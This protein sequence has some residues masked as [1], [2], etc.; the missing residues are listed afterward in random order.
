LKDATNR[1]E[2]SYTKIL[3]KGFLLGYGFQLGPYYDLVMS[4][5]RE[6]IVKFPDGELEITSRSIMMGEAIA[7][8][9]LTLNNLVNEEL[10]YRR[11]CGFRLDLPW[12]DVPQ[13]EWRVVHIGG[14]DHLLHGPPGYLDLM[15][16][17]LKKSGAMI[18]VE[19]HGIS[20]K[21]VK[22]TEKFINIQNI[23]KNIKRDLPLNPEDPKDAIIVDSI[24]VRL[25]EKGLSTLLAKDNKNVAVG[26]ASQ[27]ARTI[28]WLPR[29]LYPYNSIMVYRE[30]FIKRMGSLLP[31]RHKNPRAFAQVFLP[32][33]IGGY[34]LGP[35][36]E[37]VDWLRQSPYP[38]QKMISKLQHG[39]D[40]RHELRLL[41]RINT[42]PSRRG[43][44]TD[45]VG[46]FR[47]TLLGQLE[48][49]PD[50]VDAVRFDQLRVMFPGSDPRDTLRQAAG[51]GWLSFEE[52]ADYITRGLIFRELLVNNE[53]RKESFNSRPMVQTMYHIYDELMDLTDGFDVPDW[54][55]LPWREVKALVFGAK[56]Q[57]YFDTNQITSFDRAS[58]TRD[59]DNYKDSPD[60]ESDSGEPEE[61]SESFD[62]YDAP[63]ISGWSR[64]QPT[65]VVPPS[66]VQIP[67]ILIK[68][69]SP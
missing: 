64:G 37:V 18:S 25:L 6:R 5:I 54:D 39:A 13:R 45:K 14:D 31:S 1:Q 12:Q 7:K 20:K 63:Y 53:G 58:D 65:L 62:F 10:A 69:A 21:A 11:F 59:S 26:K 56:I 57:W 60:R 41:R 55:N 61:E 43:V 36:S 47:D 9:S 2:F 24:K 27:F 28:E 52:Y 29:E 33:E 42:N 30:L 3:L 8:P 49:Y 4:L 40:I 16:K 38:I 17:N 66:F 67:E 15:T 34:G 23:M 50:M 68:G 32:I 51:N 48:D 46:E 22:Y 35:W 44:S 19:K